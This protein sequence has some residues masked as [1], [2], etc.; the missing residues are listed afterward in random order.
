MRTFSKTI[1]EDFSLN[2]RSGMLVVLFLWNYRIGKKI[3]SLRRETSGVFWLPYL[4]CLALAKLLSL[5]FGCSVPFSCGIGRRVF[6]PH[7]LYG[8]FISGKACVGDD[9]TIMHQVTIGSNFSPRRA[10][11]LAPVLGARTFVGVGAKLIGGIEIG[12]DAKIGANAVVIE[13]IP[14]GAVCRAPKADIK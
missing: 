14:R 3:L 2:R 6:F 1:I 13:S 5:I 10:V 12:A 7:G 11:T 9:C 8:V 4:S